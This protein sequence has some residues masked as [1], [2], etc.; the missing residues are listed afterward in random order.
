MTTLSQSD[1]LHQDVLDGEK[2][3]E[4]TDILDTHGAESPQAL[5]FRQAH[6]ELESR[7]DRVESL[8]ALLKRDPVPEDLIQADLIAV[9][10]SITLKVRAQGD[11]ALKD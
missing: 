7:L 10:Q 9:K 8:K 3:G 2:L 4:F 5:E 11:K 1:S 6:P